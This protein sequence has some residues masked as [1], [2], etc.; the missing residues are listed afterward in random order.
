M[1]EEGRRASEEALDDTEEQQHFDSIVQAF[2]DYETHCLAWIRKREHDLSKIPPYQ[3]Q[4]LRECER[5]IQT[6]R[7]GLEGN[8]RKIQMPRGATTAPST[9]PSQTS[10]TS[11][12]ACMG[13]SVSGRE[14]RK[15]ERVRMGEGES[16]DESPREGHTS[17]TPLHTSSDACASHNTNTSL[18][19]SSL[20][21]PLFSALR[22]AISQNAAFLRQFSSPHSLFIN[23]EMNF[24]AA[25]PPPEASLSQHSHSPLVS[26]SEKNLQVS[27]IS[28][29]IAHVHMLSFVHLIIS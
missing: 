4:L 25:A 22:F 13:E 21:L 18:H 2:L 19:T 6:Q 9:H 17:N 26:S 20:S 5:E 16:Q 24:D 27:Y 28:L 1:E 10:R 15:R 14:L 7:G 3:M 29:L 11:E 23:K 12:G 8:E